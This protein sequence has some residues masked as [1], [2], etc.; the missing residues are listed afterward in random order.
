[1]KSCGRLLE[2]SRSMR[3]LALVVVTFIDLEYQIIPDGITLSGIVLGLVFS[4]V[5]PAWHHTTVYWQGFLWALFGMALGGGCLYLL[6]T[7]GDLLL[8]K[9]TMGG[10]D[11]KFLAAVGAFLGWKGVLLTLFLGSVMGAM[12]GIF[13]KYVRKEDRI[14][15]GPYLALG[16]L[17]SLLW[18]EKIISWYLRLV[19]QY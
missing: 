4:S 13:V 7:V 15:F 10:G 1:M 19:L 2:T 12:I 18:G 14:P 17:V 16:T 11:V 8:K 9:E 5:Y 3:T 6:G